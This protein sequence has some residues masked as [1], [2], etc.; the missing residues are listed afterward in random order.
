MS[1]VSVMEAP[2]VSTESDADFHRRAVPVIALGESHTNKDNWSE[3]VHLRTDAI[4]TI[5]ATGHA[6]YAKPDQQANAGIL[7]KVLIDGKLVSS[8][9][10][11]EGTSATIS[12]FAAA[13]HSAFVRKGKHKLEVIRQDIGVHQQFKLDVVYH[14]TAA[15]D[16]TH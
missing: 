13:S 5:S 16:L 14:A 8:N 12:F 9:L 11:F 1:E 6:N 3:D 4:L 2:K 15:R 10:T 7:L